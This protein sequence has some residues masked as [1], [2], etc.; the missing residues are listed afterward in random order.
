M[1]LPNSQRDNVDDDNPLIKKK[2]N[3]LTDDRNP[4]LI[5]YFHL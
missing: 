3:G 4:L 5:L 1:Q 2:N